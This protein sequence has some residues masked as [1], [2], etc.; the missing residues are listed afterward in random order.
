MTYDGSAYAEE[1]FIEDGIH[2]NHQG[3][4]L[5]CEN[6]IAPAIEGLIEEYGLQELRR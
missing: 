6:Y 2:L 5:W 4:L 3:Q 1:L